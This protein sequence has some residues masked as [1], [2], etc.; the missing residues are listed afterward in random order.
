MNDGPQSFDGIEDPGE[1]AADSLL[2]AVYQELRQLARY[3]M[4]NEKQG[5]TLQ[6]TA[7]VHEAWLRLTGGKNPGRFENRRHF[8]GA[9]AE[10]MRRI[11]VESAR[12]KMSVRHGGKLQRE[13]LECVDLP[14]P[15]PDDDLLAMHDAL[16]KLASVE[17]RAAELVK[18]CFFVGLT[19]AQAAEEMGVSRST[20]ER[21]WAFARAWLFREI[22]RTRGDSMPGG[23]I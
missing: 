16:D 2:P 17:A 8:F 12:R 20:A 15:M 23:F 7:L 14:A 22:K 10:A 3:R 6:P 13:D 21:L 5:H 11:L 9:A 19:Q 18:L 4:A 1:L